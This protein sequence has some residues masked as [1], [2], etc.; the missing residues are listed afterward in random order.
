VQHNR[1]E[2]FIGFSLTSEKPLVVEFAQNFFINEL[3]RLFAFG[4]GP[5]IRQI[6]D[7]DLNPRELAVGR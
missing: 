1:L 3:L 4:A 6:I 5:G 2:G 7:D